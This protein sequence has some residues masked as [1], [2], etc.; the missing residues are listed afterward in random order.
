MKKSTVVLLAVSG[1]GFAVVVLVGVVAGLL[2]LGST[3]LSSRAPTTDEKE[4]LVPV[5]R[6]A[7]I[8]AE[9]RVPETGES[10]T[11]KRNIDLSLE[12]E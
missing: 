11:A 6:L 5:E 7:S 1:A 4:L 10:Y 3:G 8:G 9:V 12:I 2:Y